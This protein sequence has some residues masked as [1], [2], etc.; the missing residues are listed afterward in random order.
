MS[1]T[2]STPYPRIIN[3]SVEEV[4]IAAFKAPRYRELYERW[5]RLAAGGRLPGYDAF[6]PE[7]MWDV[8]GLIMLADVEPGDPPIFRFRLYGTKLAQSIGYDMTKKTVQEFR[9]KVFA[10][11]VQRDYETLLRLLRPTSHAITAVGEGGMRI[12]ARL[13]LPLSEDGEHIDTIFSVNEFWQG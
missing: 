2:P 11:M 6:R 8:V 5:R 13:L 3:S 4:D 10:E 1:L 9:S 7:T 12:F